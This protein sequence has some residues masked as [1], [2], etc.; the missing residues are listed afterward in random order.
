MN[1]WDFS[2]LIDYWD[3]FMAG[4]GRTVLASL[5]GL[6][7]SLVLGTL[8]AILR[9]APFRILNVVGTVYV[10]FIRNIPLLVTV[11]FFFLGVPA[12]GIA[13]EPFTAGTLGL[14]V[15]TAAFVA[16][17]IRAG[18][19]A[20]PSGQS[21]AARSSGLSY[22]QTMRY[23]ILPQ[24]VKIVLPAIGNQMI[25]LVKNSSVLAVIAGL[26][27]MYYADIINLKTFKGIPVY[28][29][30]ALFYLLLTIPLS[31]AV[32]YMERRFAKSN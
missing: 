9:I 1:L 19:Q 13:M 11:F 22:I 10:E 31:Q 5:L 2:I 7:G 15:Y 24:A 18:I 6:I 14:I 12:L 25:N 20:V 17:S 29:L 27:L 26:D 32:H 16:E 8:I 28:T 23:I 21:E 3:D 30:V 4:L